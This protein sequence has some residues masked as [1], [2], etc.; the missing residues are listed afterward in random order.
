MNHWDAWPFQVFKWKLLSHV[1][2][3][4]TPFSRQGYWNGQPLPSPGDLPNPEITPGLPHCRWILY[5]LSHQKSLRKPTHEPLGIPD[6]GVPK[7][8]PQV[9]PIS[10]ICPWHTSDLSANSVCMSPKIM[11]VSLC[12]QLVKRKWKPTPVFLPGESHG[13]RSLVVYSPCGRKE[14]DTTER[15]HLLACLL[16][17][18]C[19]NQSDTTGLKEMI[20]TWAFSTAL[21]KAKN[22]VSTWSGFAG[23]RKDRQ[24]Y[25]IHPQGITRSVEPC[26]H[27]KSLKKSPVP[28]QGWWKISCSWSQP[29]KP[30]EVV[31][32][33]DTSMFYISFMVTIKQNPTVDHKDKDEGI[34]AQEPKTL[35]REQPLKLIV[36][37]G[38]NG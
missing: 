38:K 5:Q 1:W 21:G 13:R 17:K 7:T 15:L 30:E 28:K 35:N 36:F 10:H 18:T 34:K 29:V 33:I 12:R 9:P 22:A 16:V 6:L 24:S 27:R 14:S 8:D 2:P 26:M 4:A 11:R 32:P 31:P 3:F 20:Q 23:S 25:E 19:R 37:M